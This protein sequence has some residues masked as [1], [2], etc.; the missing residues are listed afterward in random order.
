ML[1]SIRDPLDTRLA[2]Y[3]RLNDASFRRRIEASGPFDAGMFIVEGWLALEAALDTRQQFRSILVA[4]E[5]LDRL[6]TLLGGREV[7][8][9]VA[10]ARVIE[11]VVGFDLHRGVVASAS[12]PRP[13]DAATVAA[14]AKRL[15]IVEGV[16][17][18]ENL[19]AIFRTAAALGAQGLLI[20]PTTHDPLSR[21]SIRVSLGHVLR[22]PWARVAHPWDCPPHRVIALSPRQDAVTLD[23]LVVGTDEHVAVMVGAEGPGLSDGAL[24]GADQTASIPMSPGIDS[25]NV[26]TALGIALWQL[27][28][29]GGQV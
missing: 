6:T 1:S 14:R 3:R 23:E 18:G 17:D 11:E 20:D 27:G 8:V 2:D 15:V 10:P 28:K 29:A 22:V 25:L 26:A 9:L 19:G 7:P 24:E 21:R 16:N 13:R 12:R 5:R 4:E